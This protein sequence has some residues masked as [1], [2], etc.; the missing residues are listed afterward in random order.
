MD[1]YYRRH[2]DRVHWG[3]PCYFD[4]WR[5]NRFYGCDRDCDYPWWRRGRYT[6]YLLYDDYYYY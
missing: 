3:G 6:E 2:Y 1:F 5:C 4:K